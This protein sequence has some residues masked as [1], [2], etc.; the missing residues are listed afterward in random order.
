MPLTY[1]FGP[2]GDFEIHDPEAPVRRGPPYDK[3]LPTPYALA[4]IHYAEAVHGKDFHKR[5]R[6][7]WNNDYERT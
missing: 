3:W 4:R 2:N 6:N 7:N 1:K 5:N